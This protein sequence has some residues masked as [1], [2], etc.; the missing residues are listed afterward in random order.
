MSVA[1]KEYKV[2]VHVVK[3]EISGHNHAKYY[4]G[5]T[6]KKDPE[7]RWEHGYGY[8]SNKH[9]FAAIEKYGWDNIDHNIIA[10]ELTRS[11]ACDMEKLLI[12]V[13]NSRNPRY[14]YNK[15][16]GGEGA[17]GHSISEKVR[18]MKS[19]NSKGEKNHFFNKHHS[20]STRRKMSLHHYDCSGENNPHN[21]HVY[22]FDLNGVFIRE[23]VSIVDACKDTGITDACITSAIREKRQGNNYYWGYKENVTKIKGNTILKDFSSHRKIIQHEK[24]VNQYDLEGHFIKSYESVTIAGNAFNGTRQNIIRAI[25]SNSTAYGFRWKYQEAYDNG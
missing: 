20:E 3:P 1:K 16:Y 4:V 22:K 13:Y 2:Y 7:Q 15:T 18:K 6:K 5:I 14:G 17:V 23:Y 25:K 24:P 19:E 12:A 8:R 10:R 9:F 11:E 21:R